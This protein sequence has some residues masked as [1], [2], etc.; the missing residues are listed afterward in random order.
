MV[1]GLWPNYQ[2]ASL[3]DFP[4]VLRRIKLLGLNG[5]RLPFTFRDLDAAPSPKIYFTGCKVCRCCSAA[6][7]FV[8]LILPVLLHLMS[9]CKP[10]TL[11]CFSIAC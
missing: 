9:C 4:T 6:Q 3:G 10:L 7:P 1:D 5:L 11:C 2:N 8:S